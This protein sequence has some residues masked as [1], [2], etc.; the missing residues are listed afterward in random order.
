MRNSA[1]RYVSQPKEF[2]AH[3]ARG[4]RDVEKATAI[5]QGIFKVGSGGKGTWYFQASGCR[6]LEEHLIFRSWLQF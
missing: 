2:M 1:N 5:M 3:H 4:K 6:A